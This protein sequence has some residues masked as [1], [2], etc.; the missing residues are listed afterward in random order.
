MC[1]GEGTGKEGKRKK[2]REGEKNQTT[3]NRSKSWQAS[4]PA[5]VNYKKLSVA[6]ECMLAASKDEK[7][8]DPTTELA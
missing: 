6:T 8:K 3:C 2:E 5:H 4:G 7:L 1:V